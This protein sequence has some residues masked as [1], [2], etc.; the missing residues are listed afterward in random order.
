MASKQETRSI[1]IKKLIKILKKRLSIYPSTYEAV[2]NDVYCNVN[3]RG[4]REKGKYE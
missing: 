1:E 2:I 4:I 3:P